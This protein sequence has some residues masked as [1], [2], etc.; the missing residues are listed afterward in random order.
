MSNYQMRKDYEAWLSENYGPHMVAIWD[1]NS[2]TYNKLAC[3]I[4]LEAWI[5]SRA[6]IEVELPNLFAPCAMTNE[7]L[8]FHRGVKTCKTAIESLG[9]KVK[10]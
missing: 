8:G 5:E 7:I 1:E 2:Q 3:T 4:A 6:A 10:P 9:L